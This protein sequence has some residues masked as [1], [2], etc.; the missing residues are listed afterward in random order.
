MFVPCFQVPRVHKGKEVYANSFHPHTQIAFV[1]KEGKEGCGRER[2]KPN[3]AYPASNLDSSIRLAGICSESTHFSLCH[4]PS[5]LM[6][7]WN[8]LVRYSPNWGRELQSAHVII[9]INCLGLI[10]PNCDLAFYVF[11]TIPCAISAKQNWQSSN[12]A[13]VFLE[14]KSSKIN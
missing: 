6:F 14:N 4:Q 11:S 8:F 10:N 13:G 3:P 2:Q 12:S 5:T 1:I 9:T 7:F